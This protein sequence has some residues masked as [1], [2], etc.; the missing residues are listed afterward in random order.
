M[1]I[2]CAQR[3]VQ[4]GYLSSENRGKIRT[5]FIFS[6]SK[7]RM[8]EFDLTMRTSSPS[9]PVYIDTAGVFLK[10]NPHISEVVAL[11]T[12]LLDK[13]NKVLMVGN[14]LVNPEIEKLFWTILNGKR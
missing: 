14:P 8:E 13:D 11:H 4:V 6:P 7:E 5:I 3:Y 10:D 9:L 12:F 2:L 1:F